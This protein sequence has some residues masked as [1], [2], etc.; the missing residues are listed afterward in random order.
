[1]IDW[2]LLVVFWHVDGVGEFWTSL[3]SFMKWWA[4]AP[5]ALSTA[6]CIIGLIVLR[7]EASRRLT[8]R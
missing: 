6:M 7:G 8:S 1:M 2:T 5:T 3:V 4:I